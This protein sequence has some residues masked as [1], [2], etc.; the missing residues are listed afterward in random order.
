MKSIFN[1]PLSWAKSLVGNKWSFG[2]IV[3]THIFIWAYV[4]YVGLIMPTIGAKVFILPFFAFGVYLPL[5][6]LYALRKLVVLL[7]DKHKLENS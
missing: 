6:Y 1:N 5:L 4:A 2:F 7:K 3:G